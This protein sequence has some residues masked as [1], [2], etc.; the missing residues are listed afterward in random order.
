MAKLDRFYVPKVGGCQQWGFV[1]EV[2]DFRGDCSLFYHCPFH[3][4]YILNEPNSKK[5]GIFRMNVTFLSEPNAVA[6]MSKLWDVLK[7]H[8]PFMSR[9]CRVVKYYKFFCIRKAEEAK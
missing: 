4:R 5:M 2:C 1:G 8:V 7:V 3:F 6:G 9:F